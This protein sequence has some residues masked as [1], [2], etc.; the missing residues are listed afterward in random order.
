MAIQY[1]FLVEDLEPEIK[2]LC[3]DALEQVIK[4]Q[5]IHC[6]CDDLDILVD[7]SDVLKINF[8]AI[9]KCGCGSLHGIAF[10]FSLST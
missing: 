8:N 5:R 9:L 7:T 6:P 1:K 2:N 4:N 10:P 3:K